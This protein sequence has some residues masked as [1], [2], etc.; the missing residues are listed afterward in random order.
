MRSHEN[1][2]HK[3]LKTSYKCDI[4]EMISLSK[5]ML[6]IHIYETHKEGKSKCKAK[7]KMWQM[8]KCLCF[9][10]RFMQPFHSS[11]DVEFI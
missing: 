11:V 9:C 1:K 4:C 7:L 8:W 2:T 6:R 3:D 5:V 10:K